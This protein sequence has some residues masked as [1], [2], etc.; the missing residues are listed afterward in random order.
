MGG[1]LNGT[2][3]A[4]R[5]LAEF[6]R[7][8]T[9]DPNLA[10]AYGERAISLIFVGRAEEVELQ[11]NQALRLSPRDN[12]TFVW[13]LLAGAAKIH[14]GADDQAEAWLRRSIDAN[15]NFPSE[16]MFLGAALANLGKL[17]E[18]RVE[19]RAGLALNPKFTVHR[20]QLGAES[21]NSVFLAQREHLLEGLRKAGLPEE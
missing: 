14:L 10:S 21:D 3:R 15:P 19:A 2:N 8:L 18:A 12:L 7:A 5:A 6:D 13:M 4:P 17:P 16:H 11:V 9:L 20:F 1:T